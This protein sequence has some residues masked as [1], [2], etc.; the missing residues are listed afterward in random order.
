MYMC[1]YIYIYIYITKSTEENIPLGIP[2][3]EESVIL[4]STSMEK[5]QKCVAIL[6]WLKR[7]N[8]SGT[9]RMREGFSDFN[10]RRAIS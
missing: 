10:K 7:G 4:K 9:L 3:T 1:I 5:R 2:N 6:N 8:G